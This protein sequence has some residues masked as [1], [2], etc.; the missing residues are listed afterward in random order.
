VNSPAV[1]VSARSPAADDVAAGPCAGPPGKAND[2]GS[3]SR[4]EAFSDA[5]FAFSLTL[6]VVA[7][8]VPKNFEGLMRTV[9]GFL[10]FAACFA[11]LSWLWWSHHRYFRR[12]GAADRPTVILNTVLLFFPLF[13]VY[14][15]K[16]V[17][18]LMFGGESAFRSA[19]LPTDDPRWLMIVYGGGFLGISMIFAALY[20]IARERLRR[21]GGDERARFT[22]RTEELAWLANAATAAISIALLFLPTPAAAAISGYSYFLIGPAQFTLGAMRGREERRRFGESADQACVRAARRAR[23]FIADPAGAVHASRDGNPHAARGRARRSP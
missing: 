4:L 12:F 13:Y 1:G 14:P 16:F 15:L 11:L 10:P 9:R 17:A 5:V 2:P 6:L 22:A 8:E 19:N 7:T 20:G 21:G 18:T 23:R 3:V